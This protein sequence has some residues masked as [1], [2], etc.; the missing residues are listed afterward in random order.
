MLRVVKVIF[1]G[2]RKKKKAHHSQLDLQGRVLLVVVGLY[3][4]DG[5]R[6][7]GLGHLV[8]PD[9]VA[10][11]G[12][13]GEHHETAEGGGEREEVSQRQGLGREHAQASAAVERQGSDGEVHQGEGHAGEPVPH[14]DE[15]V[16]EHHADRREHVQRDARADSDCHDPS[17][18]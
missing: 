18:R 8:R 6:G 16:Q 12:E 15:L 17:I 14:V 1:T 4:E 5:G 2:K 3:E 7:H 11:E 10:L 9:G 13:V